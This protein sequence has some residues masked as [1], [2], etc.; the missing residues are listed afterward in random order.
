MRVLPPL[1]HGNIVAQFASRT[2]R[3]E[4]GGYRALLRQFGESDE[5]TAAQC[6]CQGY[7]QREGVI[8]KEA[9]R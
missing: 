8:W 3:C 9:Q 7:L 6:G 4:H 2:D 1:L 5:I